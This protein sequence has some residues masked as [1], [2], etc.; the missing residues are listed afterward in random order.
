[1]SY[2]KIKRFRSVEQMQSKLEHSIKE[3]QKEIDEY[4]IIIGDK[5]RAEPNS[6]DPE[7]AELKE[8]LKEPTIDSKDKKQQKKKPAKKKDQKTHWIDMEA[9]SVYD[10]IGTK[11]E[12]EIYFRALDVLK[13]KM[14]NMKKSKESIDSLL[15]KGLKKDLGCLVLA[16][17]NLPHEVVFLKANDLKD[18]FNYKAVIHTNS[19][20][21]PYQTAQ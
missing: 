8:K 9:L 4:S 16:K 17:N 3:T 12:I 21:I 14:E 2:G 10:E 1:M 5:L 15:S 18:R 11:A 6:D 13:T 19:E 20:P 7:F